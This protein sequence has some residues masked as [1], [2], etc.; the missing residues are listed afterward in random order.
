MTFDTF[1]QLLSRAQLLRVLTEG[2]YLARRWEEEGSVNLYYLPDEGRGF[3]V[4]VSYNANKQG[5]FVLRSFCS[6]VP[7]E[8]YTPYV[9]LPAW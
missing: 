5:A 8:A 9:R 4:E 7:L 1:R 3:F 2:T 6:S